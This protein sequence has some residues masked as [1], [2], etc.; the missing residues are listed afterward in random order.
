MTIFLVTMNGILFR[1]IIVFYTL[2]K[3]L[4]RHVFFHL[5][6]STFFCLSPVI[7][8]QVWRGRSQA[9]PRGR[10]HESRESLGGASELSA[11]RCPPV[12]CDAQLQHHTGKCQHKLLTLLDASK[13]A[14][15]VYFTILR[16]RKTYKQK[17]KMT[18][19]S[20]VLVSLRRVS[21]S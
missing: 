21:M 1:K 15:Q 13:A 16:G 9:S 4:W 20:C 10:G 14:H 19:S 5:W 8:L 2:E 18:I 3:Y 7:Y 6:A 12:P 11:G 17:G